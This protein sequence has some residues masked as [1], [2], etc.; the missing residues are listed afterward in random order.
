MSLKDGQVIFIA[1]GKG[2]VYKIRCE[3]ETSSWPEL[4]SIL[5]EPSLDSWPLQLLVSRVGCSLSTGTD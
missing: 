3:V 1:G 5:S 4:L 2:V